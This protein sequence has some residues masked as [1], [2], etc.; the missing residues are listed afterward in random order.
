MA[1]IFRIFEFRGK[2]AAQGLTWLVRTSAVALQLHEQV[3]D[4]LTS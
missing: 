4:G 1:E 3:A 2:V